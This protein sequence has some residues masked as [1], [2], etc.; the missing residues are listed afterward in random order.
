MRGGSKHGEDVLA[1][2]QLA[3]RSKEPNANAKGRRRQ[4]KGGVK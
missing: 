1:K 4:V 2:L 3:M